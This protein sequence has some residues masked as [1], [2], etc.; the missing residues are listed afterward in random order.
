MGA[1]GVPASSGSLA[2]STETSGSDHRSLF[3]WLS[4]EVYINAARGTPMS[5]SSSAALDKY[6]ELIRY[7]YGDGRGDHFRKVMARIR[8]R[9]GQLIGAKESEV[10]LIQCTKAGEQIVLDGLPKLRSGGNIVTNDF[11]YSGS[12]HNLIGLKKSGVDVRIVK[13]SDWTVAPEAMG[14]AIDD[15]TAL[16]AITLVSNIN[17]RIEPMKEL[18]EMA[19]AKGA[20]IYADI[21]QAA[22]I[23]PLDVRKL[24]IDFAACSGYKWLFGIHGTGFLFVREEHQG[25]A[26]ADRLF[27]GHVTHNY[28]PWAAT[29][30]DAEEGLYEYHAPTDARRYQPGHLNYMGFCSL[31]EGIE[32][33]HQI[34]VDNMLAHSVKLNRRLHSQLDLDRYPCISP[35]R[36]SSPIIAYLG[37]DNATLKAL[38]NKAGVSVTFQGNRIRV[39]PAI[40]NTEEDMDLL[41]SI[42]NQA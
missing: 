41:A 17:G 29:E 13:G 27:P 40:Y 36:D 20:L 23:M 30:T 16:L 37:S 3:P 7:G 18:A 32:L 19:R 6:Q 31:Y 38:L 39:S 33:I 12:L 9:Y 15:N 4:R 42:M 1:A 24:G 25:S 10:A 11:H 26:L 34:G 14:A 35:H 5:S 21:I 2:T 8:E 28:T 22:G